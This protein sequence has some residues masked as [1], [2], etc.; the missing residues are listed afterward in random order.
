MRKIDFEVGLDKRSIVFGD[1]FYFNVDCDMQHVMENPETKDKVLLEHY[2]NL[3]IGHVEG[4]KRLI[5][6]KVLMNMGMEFDDSDIE[7]C[8]VQS[9]DELVSKRELKSLIYPFSY[10]MRLKANDQVD[11][12][13][14]SELP[15]NFTEKYHQIDKAV[16]LSNFSL[17]ARIMSVLNLSDAIRGINEFFRG[18]VYY[19]GPQAVF[20]NIE[21]GDVKILIEKCI[22]A[23]LRGKRRY[24]YN[25][26]PKLKNE[27]FEP[28][29]ETELLRFLAYA[30]FKLICVG[31]P[32]DGCDT[33]IQYP[34]LTDDAIEKMHQGNYHFIFDEGDNRHSEYIGQG[35]YARWKTLPMFV[36]LA[37]IQVFN[38]EVEDL[39]EQWNLEK[40]LVLMRKLR[41]CLVYVN[42][43]FKLC[44][45]DVSNKIMFMKINEFKI[46]A[47]AKKAI[48]W[49][50]AGV[51]YD[52]KTNGLV[53]GI[54]VEGFLENH[55]E[56]QW[57]VEFDKKTFFV[58]PGHSVK[59]E[60][61]M[62]IQLT[63]NTIIY[64]VNG[65]RKG[66]SIGGQ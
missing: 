37:Y 38:R 54:N 10:T 11:L 42:N 36:K 32:F 64:V 3:A 23:D 46:P 9:I 16:K 6:K 26:T 29:N 34:Y 51:P 2:E 50:H 30:T 49:Y 60:E 65:E 59:L 56:L 27:S 66:D 39:D 55:S 58:Q 19:I 28:M 57:V 44:D 5:V 43:Q 4:L 15:G 17:H 14:A 12:F 18:L 35:V 7:A 31:D 13:T 21:T 22:D 61:G 1:R 8:E 40:W 62:T 63:D 52:A 48:Y 33:L 20:V 45:P 41:D 24:E 25:F 47:W 53:A